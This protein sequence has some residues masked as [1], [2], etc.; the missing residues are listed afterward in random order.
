MSK[1]DLGAA[2]VEV[3]EEWAYVLQDI[4]YEGETLPVVRVGEWVLLRQ[5]GI[6]WFIYDRSGLTLVYRTES[7]TWLA[8]HLGFAFKVL[9]G[10]E[11]NLESNDCRDHLS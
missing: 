11:I 1:H 10:K 3:L 6:C 5:G 7:F 2:E 9:K 4:R 8:E